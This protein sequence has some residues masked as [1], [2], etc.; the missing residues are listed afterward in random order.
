MRLLLATISILLTV[1]SFAQLV[2]SSSMSPN[3]LVQTVF[4]GNGVTITNVNYNGSPAALGRF[5]ATG[6]NLGIDEGVIMTTGTISTSNSNGPKGP[7]N[8]ENAGLDNNAGG[9]GPLSGLI[10]GTETFNAAIL[11]FDFQ[12]CSDSIRFN[13]VFGSEEYLEYVGS[14]YNDVFAFFITG[15]GYPSPTNIAR[16]PSGAPVAINNVHSAT[17]NSFGTF[18]ALNAQY[19]VNNAGGSTIQYD[20]FTRVLTAEAAI[21]CDAVYH[22]VIAI[23]DAGDP[24]YDS[25]IF[26]EARSLT[27]SEPVKTRYVTSSNVFGNSSILAEGCASSTITLER[28]ACNISNPMDFTVTTSGTATE[29]ADYS[30]I[31]NIVTIP[32]GSQT[33]S[34]TIDAL[35]DV[36]PEGAETITIDF[37]YVDNCGN[38]R[39]ETIELSIQEP[40]PMNLSLSQT[41]NI[42]CPGDPVVLNAN[43]TGGVPPYTYDW[44]TGGTTPSITV[45]PTSTQTYAVTVNDDCSSGSLTQL[46]TV[47]VP[48]V[49]PLTLDPIPDVTEVCPYISKTFTAVANGGSGGYTYL[50]SSVGNPNLGT[51][52]NLT[53]SPGETTTYSVTVT[54]NCGA[55]TTENVTYTVTSPPLELDMDPKIQVCPGDSVLLSANASGGFGTYYYY[56]PH[57]GE[58]TPSVWVSPGRST[59]YQV[60]VSD[61]CQT[62]TVTGTTEVEVIQP[63]ADFETISTTFFNGFPITFVNES[64]GATSYFWD[65][66]NH[67]SST[68]VNPSNVYDEPGTYY[69]TLVAIDDL[70]CRDTIIKPIGIE[71]EWYI[72]VPNTFTPDGDRSNNAFSISTV[73]IQDEAEVYIFNRWGELIYTSDNIRFQWDGTFNDAYVNDGTYTYKIRFE[74]NSGRDRTIYGHVNVLK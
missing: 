64:E 69:V 34:F 56:W 62:F 39:E 3:N 70:G 22:L 37:N 9:Y 52:A 38:A 27:A 47:D 23:A 24:I 20:G 53:V 11:E 29:G 32:A 74:T 16:L 35:A 50:W 1:N 44:N 55:Q 19:Y 65:F 31:P 51:G 8:A 17:A 49:P 26:L 18:G 58:V 14:P 42:I 13:Y 67:S 46:I 48:V 4:V 43:I 41:G 5:T 2:T 68:I 6:T 21:Q 10:G 25:G 71:E 54:D 59:S 40:E 33:V 30:N 60:I 73:G 12:T 7:N 63:T 15:P 61:E 66:G 28:T 36:V 72:Y 57:S 45:N